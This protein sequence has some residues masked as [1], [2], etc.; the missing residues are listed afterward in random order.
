MVRSNR[1]MNPNIRRIYIVMIISI[2]Y[3]VAA[4]FLPLI[5]GKSLYY[6]IRLDI[7]LAYDVF[8]E[9][10]FTMEKLHIVMDG[11][12]IA[13]SVLSLIFVAIRKVIAVLVCNV[14]SN[15]VFVL[16]IFHSRLWGI[17]HAARQIEWMM[18]LTYLY[19]IA[20]VVVFAVAIYMISLRKKELK[21]A[22]VPR[23][24]QTGM[25]V[26]E[27]CNAVIDMDAKYCSRCGMPI[28]NM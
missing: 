16:R 3:M 5:Y 13:G 11:I 21:N 1:N 6:L 15:I 7:F 18:L 19:F 23:M 20:A 12:I 14:I 8:Y 4:C 2:I 17:R 26:C 27:Y 24:E 22:S 25:P 10:N 28:K 9:D